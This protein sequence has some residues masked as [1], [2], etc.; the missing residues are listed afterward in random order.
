[1]VSRDLSRILMCPMQGATQS[2]EVRIITAERAPAIKRAEHQYSF[3]TV[4]DIAAQVERVWP[5]IAE[6]LAWPQW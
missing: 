4:W 3:V 1:M 5:A 2:G 6:P